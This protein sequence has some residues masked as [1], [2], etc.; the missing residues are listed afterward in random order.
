ML[1]AT[2]ARG[3]GRSRAGGTRAWALWDEPVLFAP[4]GAFHLFRCLQSLDRRSARCRRASR[5]RPCCATVAVRPAASILKWRSSL[6]SV[7]TR[8]NI[9][10]PNLKLTLACW[11][12]DR[13]R[14]LIDGAR[15]ARRAS[16]ST[17]RSCGRAR[18]F[19]RMLDRQEFQVSELSLASY[20]ALK[21][22]RRVPVRGGAGRALENLPPLLHL[23]AHRRRHQHAAGPEGQARRHLAVELD[24]ARA[25]C[26]ACCSTTTASRP[27]DMHWFMGGLNSFV[28]P[29]L[30]ALDLP[31]DIKLDFLSGRPDAGEDVRRRASSTRCCRSISRSCSSTAR[32]AIARLFPNYQGDR[33]GLLPPHAN[34]SDHAHGGGARGCPSRASVGGAQHL[35]GVRA[36]PR[37]LA[38]DGL[39]DTDAL[40]ARAAVADRPRRGGVARLRQGLLGLWPR[41]EPADLR[42][43]RP[44]RP[45]AG[46]VARGW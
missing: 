37:D 38:V 44:L 43:D 34:S 42:G 5:P 16:I 7:V 14:P 23:R 27:Q 11:D 18:R 6:A 36:K 40:R 12:Y 22:A 24:R 46:P 26:A 41:A 1:G 21:G 20:T 15:E 17:S 3:Q 9:L 45:R 8:R 30:I 25:S 39:Y 28:E 33:A 4:T 19:Q 10:M 31:K 2:F 35:P 32:R 29:P 13:T